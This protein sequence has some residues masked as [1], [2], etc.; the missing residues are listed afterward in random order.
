MGLRVGRLLF[1]LYLWCVDQSCVDR[2]EKWT[3]RVDW[4]EKWTN[5]RVDRTE[6]W[7]HRGSNWEMEKGNSCSSGT[8]MQA[9]RA[10]KAWVG[11]LGDVGL[12][13]YSS[14]RHPTPSWQNHEGLVPQSGQTLLNGGV[15]THRN[16]KKK[17]TDTNI[18]KERIW[19][20]FFLFCFLFWIFSV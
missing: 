7:T 19:K 14:T 5:E 13:R 6:K 17:D 10:Y 1:S 12:G 9:P 16:E 11:G 20:S 2:T 4:T 15:S 18:A 3:E 8:L